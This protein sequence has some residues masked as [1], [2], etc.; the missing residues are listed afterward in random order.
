MRKFDLYFLSFEIQISTLIMAICICWCLCTC[1]N[2][3]EG[4]VYVSQRRA[5]WGGAV[6]DLLLEWR[7]TPSDFVNPV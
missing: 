1:V 6:V 7:P 2:V 5:G 4:C 3:N